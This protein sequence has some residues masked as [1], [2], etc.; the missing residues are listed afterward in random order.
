MEMWW[1]SLSSSHEDLLLKRDKLSLLSFEKVCHDLMNQE[2]L[3]R[4]FVRNPATPP[5]DQS[6]HERMKT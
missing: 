5:A 1:Y 3:G 2:K 6:V 4:L